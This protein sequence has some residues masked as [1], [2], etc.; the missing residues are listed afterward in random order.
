MEAARNLRGEAIREA[1]A[2]AFGGEQDVRKQRAWACDSDCL[3]YLEAAPLHP[4]EGFKEVEFCGDSGFDQLGAA[5][6]VV[7]EV[8]ILLLS[9]LLP[10]N[11]GFLPN[12][13]RG[14]LC[15]HGPHRVR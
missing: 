2:W 7:C 15:R 9:D 14:R 3:W 4:S 10:A 11:H 8:C 6:E 13:W 5:A 1:V 12:K